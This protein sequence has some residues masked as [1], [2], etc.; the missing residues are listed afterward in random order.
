MSKRLSRTEPDDAGSLVV[1]LEVDEI[2]KIGRIGLESSNRIVYRKVKPSSC[3][4]NSMVF[5]NQEMT[6]AFSFKKR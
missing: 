5:A 4:C 2:W 3:V 6:E 1:F